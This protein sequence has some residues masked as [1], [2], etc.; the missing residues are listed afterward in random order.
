MFPQSSHK[1][2]PTTVSMKLVN[3][4]GKDGTCPVKIRLIKDRQDSYLKTPFRSRPADWDNAAGRYRSHPDKAMANARITALLSRAQAETVRLE[5]V[6]PGAGAAEL[7]H[8]L[9]E[10]LSGKVPRAAAVARDFME[11]FGAVVAT[12]RNF[13][14]AEHM[15]STLA[16]LGRFRPAGLS[17]GEVDYPFCKAFEHWAFTTPLGKDR[18]GNDRFRK[19]STVHGYFQDMATV[20]NEARRMA[21]G[22]DRDW[23]AS[24]YPFTDFEPPKATR[25]KKTTYG[26]NGMDALRAAVP[27]GRAADLA[28]DVFLFQYNMLGMRISDVLTLQWSEVYDGYVHYD[29]AKNGKVKKYPISDEAAAILEKYRKN[30]SVYVFP[31]LK[32]GFTP[33]HMKTATKRINGGMKKLC[34]QLGIPPITSHGARRSIG[35]KL[36]S[37]GVSVDDIQKFYGH[38]DASTTKTYLDGLETNAADEVVRGILNRKKG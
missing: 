34:A 15:R 9:A 24:N 4:P 28:R 10:A 22:S 37:E 27:K 33:T 20:W 35:W 17:F 23:L 38:A 12:K 8:L 29:M 11:A 18:D 21:K 13:Y 6:H 3:V 2:M 1:I 31:V 7:R 16:I 14:T 26:D 19:P 5:G 25:G 32:R 30:K 36:R